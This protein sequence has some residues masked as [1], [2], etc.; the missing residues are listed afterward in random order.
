MLNCKNVK[1]MDKHGYMTYLRLW[2]LFFKFCLLSWVVVLSLKS[3]ECCSIC[4][5]TKSVLDSTGSWSKFSV[6]SIPF[7]CWWAESN[8]VAEEEKKNTATWNKKGPITPSSVLI[9]NWDNTVNNDQR[10][11][12]CTLHRSSLLQSFFL[13]GS[14]TFKC[15]FRSHSFSMGQKANTGDS[16]QRADT[17]SQHEPASVLGENVKTFR[18]CSVYANS[19]VPY[20]KDIYVNKNKRLRG[21]KSNRLTVSVFADPA[22]GLHPLQRTDKTTN[23]SSLGLVHRGPLWQRDSQGPQRNIAVRDR[24]GV[25]WLVL[26]KVLCWRNTVREVWEGTF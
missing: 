15:F 4:C 6:F 3:S 22:E 13:S 19:T 25:G 21:T 11:L 20:C 8:C 14:R 1:D 10:R 7:C 24:W 23:F 9:L 26:R 17:E 2:Q 12:K 5:P 16:Q 18:E